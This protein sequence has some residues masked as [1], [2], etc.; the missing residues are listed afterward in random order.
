LIGAGFG[1]DQHEIGERLTCRQIERYYRLLQR[2][3]RHAQADMIEAMAAGFGA[4]NLGK[5]LK[6]LRA[7]E[8]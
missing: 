8:P 4:K 6:S 3:R 2:R 5:L 7:D 1:H